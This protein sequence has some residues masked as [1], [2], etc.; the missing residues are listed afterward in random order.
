MQDAE[1]KRRLAERSAL[2]DV[3]RELQVPP[4]RRSRGLLPGSPL[5]RR[6]QAGK[7][8]PSG[9]SYGVVQGTA[10]GLEIDVSISESVGDTFER[11]G[12]CFSLFW[13]SESVLEHF[14]ETPI[15]R[16]FSNP[17]LV[18][19]SRPGVRRNPGPGRARGD[20]GLRARR[21]RRRARRAP[22]AREGQVARGA[23]AP[24]PRRVGMLEGGVAVQ[25]TQSVLVPK[26]WLLD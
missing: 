10:Q 1:E 2:E 23:S 15:F 12:Q 6:F 14:G 4:R 9:A 13:C 20:G 22:G 7:S 26:L 17:V 25:D 24:N 16:T 18:S 8:G 5:P 19:L 21:R 3:I 11:S